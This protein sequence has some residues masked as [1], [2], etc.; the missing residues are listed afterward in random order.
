MILYKR[1]QEFFDIRCETKKRSVDV[2][3]IA[4]VTLG[5]NSGRIVAITSRCASLPPSPLPGGDIA[6]DVTE[7][8]HGLAADSES[9]VEN[10]CF[11]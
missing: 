1:T 4:H 3:N 8:R 11:G 2:I 10:H 7:E 5:L 9:C 6:E